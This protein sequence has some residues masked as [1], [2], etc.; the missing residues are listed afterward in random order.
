MPTYRGQATRIPA[1]RA[2]AGD[3]RNG[4]FER[5]GGY[6]WRDP[7]RVGPARLAQ[8]QAHDGKIAAAPDRK[9]AKQE[10]TDEQA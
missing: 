3:S 9:P 10:D 7:R 6:R 2:G 4:L 1:R 5:T 8:L